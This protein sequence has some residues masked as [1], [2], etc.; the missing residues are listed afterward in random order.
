VDS[1]GRNS[2]A[3]QWGIWSKI[4]DSFVQC[5]GLWSKVFF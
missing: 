5:L 2:N 3:D 4:I 1:P